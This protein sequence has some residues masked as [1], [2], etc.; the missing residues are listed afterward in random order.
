MKLYFSENKY[1]NVFCVYV[2]SICTICLCVSGI[3]H[4]VHSGGGVTQGHADPSGCVSDILMI[5][6][7]QSDWICFCTPGGPDA[8]SVTGLIPLGAAGLRSC[9]TLTNKKQSVH[10]PTLLFTVQLFSTMI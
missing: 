1:F 10:W 7:L 9:V 8:N 5:H 6:T 3:T 2:C 4:Q